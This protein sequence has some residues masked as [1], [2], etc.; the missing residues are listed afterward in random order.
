MRFTYSVI[1]C[2]LNYILWTVNAWEDG[3]Y[4]LGSK[5]ERCH[6]SCLTWDDSSSWNTCP[7]TRY[8]DDDTGLWE[9]CPY[10]EFYDNTLGI[11][12]SWN[13]KCSGKWAYQSICFQCPTNQSFDLST[14]KWV[15][16]CSQT[17]V[18]L[19][20]KQFH[21]LNFW[22]N[23]K[24][25]VNPDSKELIEL[26]TLKYPYKNLGTV[27]IEV[28]NIHSHSNRTI[29]IYVKEK[30]TNYLELKKNIIMNITQV[31]IESYSE[32]DPTNPSRAKVIVVETPVTLSSPSTLFNVMKEFTRKGRLLY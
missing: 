6:F 17:Q 9:L 22:R 31:S 8:L 18:K 32:H 15:Q 12:K 2:A 24:Y 3:Y 5:W 1:V 11:C 20:E 25:Y 13:G 10:G 14:L 4:E 27:F 16:T 26:G 19:N 7:D 29:N 21:S 28:F 23:L 30:S